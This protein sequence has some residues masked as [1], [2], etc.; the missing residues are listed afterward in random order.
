[1]YMR[2]RILNLRKKE[3]KTREKQ[4]HMS[5]LATITTIAQKRRIIIRKIHDEEKE[6]ETEDREIERGKEGDRSRVDQLIYSI[7]MK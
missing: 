2:I 7:E 5:R 4:I 1:M 3:K 6:A